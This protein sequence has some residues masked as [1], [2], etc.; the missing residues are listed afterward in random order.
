MIYASFQLPNLQIHTTQK[1][2]RG[3]QM[4]AS[5]VV[6]AVLQGY[7]ILTPCML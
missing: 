3:Y 4:A 1:T 6:V 7:L 2:N 5:V